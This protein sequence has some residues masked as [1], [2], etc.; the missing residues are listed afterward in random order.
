MTASASGG[1]SSYGLYNDG[2]SSPTL[3]DVTLSASGAATNIGLNNTGSGTVMTNVRVKGS[4]TSN[5]FG[6]YNMGSL[7][8]TSVQV[9]GS[10]GT[11]NYGLHKAAS[12]GTYTVTIN[13]SEIIGSSYTINNDT[14]FPTLVGASRLEG[15]PVSGSVTC[16]GVYDENYLFSASTCP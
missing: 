5:N 6:V 4:G 11:S 13:H 2:S 1:T 15:G 9:E 3:S 8:M 10:G 16:A 14:E 12:T 7:T